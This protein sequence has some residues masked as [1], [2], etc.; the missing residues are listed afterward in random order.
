[1]LTHALAGVAELADALDLG[2]SAERRRGS[3]P[4]SRTN[5]MA[6]FQKSSSINRFGRKAILPTAVSAMPTR[7][8]SGAPD[9][10]NDDVEQ[11]NRFAAASGEGAIALLT[12]RVIL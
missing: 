11:W 1:M 4:L 5:L 2:S 6:Q 7:P 3:S 12:T 8:R 9:G 10:A